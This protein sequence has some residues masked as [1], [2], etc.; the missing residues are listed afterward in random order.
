MAPCRC[1]PADRAAPVDVVCAARYSFTS[2]SSP[3]GEQIFDRRMQEQREALR[4]VDFDADDDAEQAAPDAESAPA[5]VRQSV[6]DGWR[7]TSN[8]DGERLP[9][10]EELL[11]AEDEAHLQRLRQEMRRRW[12]EIHPG[13]PRAG[14]EGGGADRRSAATAAPSAAAAPGPVEAE[15]DASDVALAKYRDELARRRAERAQAL[16]PGGGEMSDP[17]SDDGGDD[18]G[19]RPAA[20]A[21]ARPA[22]TSLRQLRQQARERQSREEA[23]GGDDEERPQLQIIRDSPPTVLSPEAIR[24]REMYDEYAQLAERRQAQRRREDAAQ[25]AVGATPAPNRLMIA[26][27]RAVRVSPIVAC[28]SHPAPFWPSRSSRGGW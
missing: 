22:A 15:E 5:R 2:V 25:T 12:N 4:A 1:P 28:A 16:A 27:V 11:D 13:V 8:L 7:P 24:Q 10:G 14:A 3:V 17:R 18:G 19:V 26:G 9:S 20:E 21:P 6:P 23:G